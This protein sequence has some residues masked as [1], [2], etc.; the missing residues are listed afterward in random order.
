MITQK[1]TAILGDNH[2]GI[3]VIANV[4]QVEFLDVLLD[5]EKREFRP[6]RKPNST[7]RYIHSQ[8][9]HP[10][11]VK[12]GLPEMINTRIN[13]LSSNKQIFE[14]EKGHYEKSMQ[15]SGFNFKMYHKKPVENT[16]KKSQEKGRLSGSILLGLI[17]SGYQL[18]IFS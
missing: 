10:P 4:K 11:H 18:A 13:R 16:M 8:S 12:K 2:F 3:E 14:E 1:L 7:T 5:L 17:M 6:Y 15:A 9:N